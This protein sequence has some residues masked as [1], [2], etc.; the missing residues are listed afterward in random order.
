[1]GNFGYILG[2]L[3]FFIFG[4]GFLIGTAYERWVINDRGK[5]N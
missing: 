5:S 4:I 3:I 1:M 2:Y